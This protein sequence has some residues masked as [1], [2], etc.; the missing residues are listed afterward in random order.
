[1]GARAAYRYARQML[2][3]AAH[4]A[5]ESPPDAP[6][7]LAC[8]CASRPHVRPV[9]HGSLPA[10]L[11]QPRLPAPAAP[12]RAPPP[13]RISVRRRR[14]SSAVR[15]RADLHALG[16]PGYAAANRTVPPRAARP[17]VRERD[18]APP[19]PC[20]DRSARHCGRLPRPATT[21][22]RQADDREWSGTAPGLAPDG[23]DIGR[24]PSR[25]LV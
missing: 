14:A 15:H 2:T 20:P 23:Y 6:A 21:P 22:C 9:P 7:P 19:G 13:P 11:A 1:A 3:D 18:A 8:E 24:A 12:C 16:R 4:D 25:A 5:G 10:P 17:T